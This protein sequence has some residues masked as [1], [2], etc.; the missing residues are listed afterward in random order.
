MFLCTRATISHREP[1]RHYNTQYPHTTPEA[2]SEAERNMCN[3]FLFNKFI[4]KKKV[5]H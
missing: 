3:T 5:K 4:L 1:V 2:V